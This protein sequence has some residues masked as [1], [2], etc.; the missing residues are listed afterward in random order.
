MT[1]YLAEVRLRQEQDLLKAAAE[2]YRITHEAIR[3]PQ[4]RRSGRSGGFRL[5][6][7]WRPVLVPVR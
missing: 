7:G 4:D 1:P 3:R 5:R 2:R 6:W